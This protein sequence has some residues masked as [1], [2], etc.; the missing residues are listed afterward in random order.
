MWNKPSRSDYR[1]NRK[2]EMITPPDNIETL[3][4]SIFATIRKLSSTIDEDTKHKIVGKKTIAMA[5]SVQRL[6]DAYTA[7]EELKL[8]KKQMAESAVSG[9][10]DFV[11]LS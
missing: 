7:L 3:T 9:N 1:H 11:N 10:T 8:L 2:L 6:T 4:D 5:E